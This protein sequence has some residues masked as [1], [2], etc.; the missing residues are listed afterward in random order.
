MSGF[1]CK[2]SSHGSSDHTKNY[3]NTAFHVP[4]WHKERHKYLIPVPE[5]SVM[6]DSVISHDRS[7]SDDYLTIDR[8]DEY[9][10]DLISDSEFKD[11]NFSAT[12][13]IDTCLWNDND[14]ILT[15]EHANV[16]LSSLDFDPS[17]D[18]Q[19]VFTDLPQSII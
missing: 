11:Q 3:H 1:P 5:R 17:L 14:E 15:E 10:Q 2:H 7:S 19:N 16:C 6:T 12:Y 4:N 13:N 9:T 8:F 18:K